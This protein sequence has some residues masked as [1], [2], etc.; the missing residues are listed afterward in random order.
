MQIFLHWRNK[1]KTKKQCPMEESNS[2]H[3]CVNEKGDAT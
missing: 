1:N 3:I 2:K